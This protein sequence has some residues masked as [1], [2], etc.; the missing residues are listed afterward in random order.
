MTDL[1][2]VALQLES[3]GRIGHRGGGIARNIGELSSESL[4]SDGHSAERKPQK[5]VDRQVG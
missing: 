1:R 5:F 4:R 3:Q 2:A